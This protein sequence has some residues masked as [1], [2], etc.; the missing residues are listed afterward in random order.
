MEVTIK[1]VDLGPRISTDPLRFL[2]Y[3]NASSEFVSWGPVDVTV[4]SDV[5]VVDYKHNTVVGVQDV[6][7]GNIAKI[8]AQEETNGIQ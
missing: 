5:Q 7:T 2:G 1:A 4:T 8:D 3:Y 6:Y